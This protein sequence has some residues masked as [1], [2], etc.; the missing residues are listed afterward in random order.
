MAKQATYRVASNPFGFRK[1]ELTVLFAGDSQTNP[2][3]R[4]G[5]KVVDYYL[6]HHVLSGRGVF[7]MG[8]V[9]LA[10]GPGDSFLIY[11][12]KLFHY[13]SD[14]MNPWRYRWVA[15]SGSSAAALVRDAGFDPERPWTHTG[16]DKAPGE[17]CRAIFEA[18]RERSGSA[19]LAASGHLH[20]LLASLREASGD[21]APALPR[22]GTHSEELARQVIGYLSTQYAEPITIEGMAEALGYNRAYL[23]RVFKQHAGVSPATFLTKLRVDQGRRL[24]RERPELTVEQ[25]ASS[26]GFQDAL[27]FSK[28][29]RRWYAQS[30]TEYRS[31]VGDAL[32]M[33]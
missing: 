26:V 20:L 27:Y 15:F 32:K 31:A 8:D 6:L 12:G 22:P 23:S 1:R 24:L 19:S 9:E 7:R 13:V 11:P 18:F 10:L 14:E 3:H 33:K 21:S 2:Q 5:P 28:Q 16:E 17:R 30:P 25:I 4:I 29:F